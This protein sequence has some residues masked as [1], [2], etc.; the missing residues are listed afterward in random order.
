MGDFFLLVCVFCKYKELCS[1]FIIIKQE[2]KFFKSFL[3]VS[4]SNFSECVK[5]KINVMSYVNS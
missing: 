1:T 2:C 3:L 5:V 4:E